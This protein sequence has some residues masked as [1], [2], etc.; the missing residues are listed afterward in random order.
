MCGLPGNAHDRA[1]GGTVTLRDL[2]DTLL[3]KREQEV[4]VDF[5]V[6]RRSALV[7]NAGIG[8]ARGTSQHPETE[9][10]LKFVATHEAILRQAA[11]LYRVPGRLDI[12][13]TGK[14]E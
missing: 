11:R 1:A 10:F 3:H 9:R 12:Q 7:P 13:G 6:R 4:P 8:S 5:P 14:P 2:V